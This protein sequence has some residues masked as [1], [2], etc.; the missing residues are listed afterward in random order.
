MNYKA[1]F[2][3]AFIISTVMC[4]DRYLSKELLLEHLALAEFAYDEIYK[5]TK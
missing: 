5:R 1:E 2:L 4:P 3:K